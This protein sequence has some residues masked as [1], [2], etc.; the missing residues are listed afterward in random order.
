MEKTQEKK[1]GEFSVIFTEAA[2]TKILEATQGQ[3]GKTFLRIQAKADGQPE[4]SYAMKLI[5]ETEKSCDDL[6]IDGGGFEVVVDPQSAGNLTGA[7]IDFEDG[8]VRSG[9]KFTN[10]NK[11]PFPSVETGPREDLVGSLEDK[12]RHLIDSELNPAVA[13]HGGQINLVGVKENKVYLSFGGGC[14]GCG[15]VKVTLKNGVEARIRELLPEIEEVID[16]TDH[17]SGEN[18]FYT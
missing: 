7:S 5:R 11:P 12:V 10:P 9:F 17:R 3:E 6:S 4:F 8:A 18:P 15:M 13:G 16:I 14:H 2:K 1:S